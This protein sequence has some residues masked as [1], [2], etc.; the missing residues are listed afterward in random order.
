MDGLQASTSN[1]TLQDR[2]VLRLDK[3]LKHGQ[4]LDLVARLGQALQGEVADRLCRS[5]RVDVTRVFH[6]YQIAEAVQKELSGL[7]MLTEVLPFLVLELFD[8]L[9]LLCR[10]LNYW[11]LLLLYLHRVILR[12]KFVWYSHA[13]LRTMRCWHPRVILLNCLLQVCLDRD[14]R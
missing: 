7:R 13:K 3:H 11:I 9:F 14:A 8:F 6:G 10:F 1:K 5:H 12:L 4:S 2:L